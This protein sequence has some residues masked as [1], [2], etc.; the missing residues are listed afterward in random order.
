MFTEKKEH[1][2]CFKHSNNK[3]GDSVC[4]SV[5]KYVN[6]SVCNG[7]L[8]R[9]KE[10]ELL[11]CY[12]AAELRYYHPEWK[13]PTTECLIIEYRSL[14]IPG[15]ANYSEREGLKSVWV[16]TGRQERWRGVFWRGEGKNGM[17]L[18]DCGNQLSHLNENYFLVLKF[19]PFIVS[20]WYLNL[21]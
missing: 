8:P 14:Q 19:R 1:L 13:K 20:Y 7:I 21:F 9:N 15:G 18:S 4:L 5:S 6:H 11:I 10:S 3:R 16:R 2:N 12:H 17:L